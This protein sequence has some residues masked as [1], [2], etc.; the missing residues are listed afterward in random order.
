MNL[1]VDVCECGWWE[2]TVKNMWWW[3]F[4]LKCVWW[5]VLRVLWRL[6]EER[7]DVPS[8]RQDICIPLMWVQ[9]TLTSSSCNTAFLKVVRRHSIHTS[10]PLHPFNPTH[11]TQIL[12]TNTQPR[13]GGQR[14]TRALLIT[15]YSI[16]CCLYHLATT[17]LSL[18]LI[19]SSSFIYLL[20]TTGYFFPIC[21]FDSLLLAHF[22][23]PQLTKLC[24]RNL[25]ARRGKEWGR[26]RENDESF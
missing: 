26:L 14:G 18:L 12:T 1:W 22:I 3:L 6:R 4:Y 5:C 2:R 16:T 11:S 8:A 7:F 21:Y 13:P 15:Q 17:V 20:Y 10:T 23:V 24:I 9:S 19:L 25:I